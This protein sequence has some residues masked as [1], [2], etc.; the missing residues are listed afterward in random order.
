MIHPPESKI[1][2]ILLHMIKDCALAQ[3]HIFSPEEMAFIDSHAN[4]HVL[5]FGQDSVVISMLHLFLKNKRVCWL[6]PK[7]KIVI[8]CG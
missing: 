6:Q 8:M 3:K 1:I 7:S 4:S 5:D 2:L